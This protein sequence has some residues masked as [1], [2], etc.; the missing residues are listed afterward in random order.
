MILHTEQF[1]TGEPVVFL[2]TGLQTGLTDFVYQRNHLKG[3]YRVILPD[4]RGHGKSAA[5]D[6]EVF[7]EASAIDLHETLGHLGI[8]SAH[9]IGGS[10]GAL[11]GVYFA[12]RFPEC[13]KSL[14]LSGITKEQ[15]ADWEALH[16]E[17]VRFQTLLLTNAEASAFFDDLHGP[18]WQRFIHMGRSP[19]W[20]PFQETNS[21][22]GIDA[23]ILV[24]AGEKSAHEVAGAVAYKKAQENIQIA[25][26]PFA[27][28]LVHAEQPEIF[29]EVLAL[30]LEECTKR[31]AA[32]RDAVL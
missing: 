27:A 19:E 29:T 18:G 21:L 20:Y 8:P 13:V 24:L 5:A 6:I 26:I 12:K 17:D 22:M 31:P 11:V 30:F 16:A 28:H 32:S 10:L 2:H 4:L 1:G 7:F 3:K 9:I 14:G 15:P 23:P 25:V